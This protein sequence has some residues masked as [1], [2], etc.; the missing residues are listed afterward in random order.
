[1]DYKT[2]NPKD[3]KQALEDFL[4]DL[5]GYITIPKALSKEEVAACNATLNDIPA[6][7]PGD[8]VGYVHN[9]VHAP[10]LGINYQQIYE[11]GEPF[12]RLIDHDSWNDRVLRYVGGQGSFDTLHGPIFIDEAFANLRGVGQAISLHSG[13]QDGCVRTQYR[14]FNGQWHCGQ[15]NILIALTDIGPGDGATMVI[16]G[17]HK[18]NIRHPAFSEFTYGEASVDGIEGAIEVHLEAGDAILFVDAIAH[19]SAARTNSG[20]RRI[21]VYRYG[22]SWGRSRHGYVPSDSLMAGLTDRQRSYIC[23]GIKRVSGQGADVRPE[24]I[25]DH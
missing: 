18:S 11:A 20:E 12:A 13:G 10:K 8:W 15:V 9:Q 23:P 22:P 7:K 2:A 14:Y 17:S 1:M 19:G 4:F 25:N 21:C 6:S 3:R 24:G 5:N 16:P